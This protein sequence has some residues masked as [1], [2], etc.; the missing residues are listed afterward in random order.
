ML[1]GI[2]EGV[3]DGEIKDVSEVDADPLLENEFRGVIETEVIGV[4][5]A[6][7]VSVNPGEADGV[8]EL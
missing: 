3:N 5:E 4:N 2:S 7:G 6:S 1:V 8:S